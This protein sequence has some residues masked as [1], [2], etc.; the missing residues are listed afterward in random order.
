MTSIATGENPAVTNANGSVASPACSG[1]N[2]RTIWKYWVIMKMNP[3]R[4]KNA[5]AIA[6][7]A[8]A[9]RGLRNSRTSSIGSGRRACH[10]AKT[11]STTSA[12]P[13]PP[14]V[15]ADPQPCDGASM[16]DQVSSAIPTIDSSAP[17]GSN[18]PACGSLDSGSS[19]R[20]PM[21]ATTATGTDT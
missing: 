2:P 1:E 16:I 4:P 3:N 15:A 13:I 12:P 21:S 19:S 5:S 8:A 10:Q 14:T 18:R 20:P 11:A 9:N 7:L 6:P 17:N